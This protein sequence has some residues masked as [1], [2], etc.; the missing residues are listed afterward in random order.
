[1]TL[2]TLLQVPR[3][4]RA[5]STPAK[6]FTKEVPARAPAISHWNVQQVAQPGLSIT[7]PASCHRNATPEKDKFRSKRHK[8]LQADLQPDLM[9]EVRLEIG[10]EKTGLS[11]TY[12]IFRAAWSIT[13]PAVCLQKT[14]FDGNCSTENGIRCSVGSWPGRCHASRST[15]SFGSVWY[16]W[17]LDSH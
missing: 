3:R 13:E 7:E 14:P 15:W 1:M 17:P 6:K 5:I 16:C 10:S 11:S 9:S 2:K 12:C 8:E 4:S